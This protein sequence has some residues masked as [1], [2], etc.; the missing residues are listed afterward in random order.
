MPQSHPTTVPVRFLALVQFLAGKAEYEF[1][2]VAV[3]VVTSGYGPHT[4]WHVCTLMV[5]SNNSQDSTWTPCDARVDAL[6]DPHGN[7][8]CVSYLTGPVRGPY[9]IHNGAIRHP[10][11]HVRELRQ[12]EFTKIP[13]ERRIW[14]YGVRASPLQSRQGLFTD[15]LLYL[16]PHGSC[17]LIMHALK[18]YG[19]R[20]GRQNSYGTSR[21]DVRFCSKRPLNSPRTAHKWFGSVLSGLAMTQSNITQYLFTTWQRLYRIYVRHCTHKEHHILRLPLINYCWIHNTMSTNWFESQQYIDKHFFDNYG[22]KTST[23][24]LFSRTFTE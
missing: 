9:G 23:S 10:Y 16:N 17:K 19:P 1:Y 22:N 8:Q 7:P 21:V 4:A 5:W 3:P 12:P 14:P 15:C 2:A 13:H 11:G 6:R 24:R 20:T 18:L